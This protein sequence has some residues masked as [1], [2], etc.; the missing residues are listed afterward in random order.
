MYKKFSSENLKVRA[1]SEDI[2]VDGS[3]I[4]EW[5]L[6]KYN[7]KLGTG[8]IWHRIGTSGGLL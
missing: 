6:G 1:H 5:N 3:L 7:E 8:C 4:L 2:G